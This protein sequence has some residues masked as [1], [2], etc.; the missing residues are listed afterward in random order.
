MSA[1]PKQKPNSF[2]DPSVGQA[3][4]ASVEKTLESYTGIKPI[5]E[6]H[7]L[8]QG[9]PT[10]FEYYGIMNFELAG[11]KAYMILALKKDS[12]KFIY[13]R[14]V[15]ALPDENS[16][17]SDDCVG[18]LTNITYGNAKAE[19]SKQGFS[20]SMALPTVLRQLDPSKYNIQA[21]LMLPFKQQDQFHLAL[22][23]AI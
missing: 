19:L 18:E 16:G 12:L 23:L 1:A 21:S 14:M 7:K 10:D 5:R 17:E 11:Q 13:E 9:I 2:F 15:G 6:G 3:F 4:I 20:M 8:F 22:Y